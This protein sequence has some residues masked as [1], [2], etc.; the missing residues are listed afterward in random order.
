[1]D[2]WLRAIAALVAV[3]VGCIWLWQSYSWEGAAA[4][5]VALLIALDGEEDDSPNGGH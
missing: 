5:L 2:D 4:L 1:M 3:S